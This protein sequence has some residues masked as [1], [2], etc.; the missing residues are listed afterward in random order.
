MRKPIKEITS[1]E[2]RRLKGGDRL[3]YL[4]WKAGAVQGITTK[5]EDSRTLEVPDD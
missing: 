3:T 2:S 5:E 4:I 1:E